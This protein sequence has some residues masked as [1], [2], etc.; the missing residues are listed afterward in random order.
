MIK[1]TLKI[2]SQWNRDQMLMTAKISLPRHLSERIS[3][4]PQKNFLQLKRL[5]V[6]S[7]VLPDLKKLY[8]MSQDDLYAG[9]IGFPGISINN[10]R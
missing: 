6:H 8:F 2:F 4:I 3:D 9:Y 5:P 7:P 10:F 1:M